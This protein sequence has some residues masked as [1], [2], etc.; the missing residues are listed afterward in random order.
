MKIMVIS[1]HPDDETLGAG[2]SLLKLKHLG[3]KIYWLNI[4]DANAG[5]SMI[6]PFWR[7]VKSR[8]KGLKSILDF[9]TS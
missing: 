9:Q 3:N 1:P 4:T 5:G 8:L 6:M 7:N 2:G